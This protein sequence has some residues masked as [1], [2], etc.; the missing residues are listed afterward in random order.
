MVINFRFYGLLKDYKSGRRS[1]LSSRI[2]ERAPSE[3]IVEAKAWFQQ[4]VE[5]SGDRMPDKDLIYLTTCL[6]KK[7]LF[8][9]YVMHMERY[10]KKTISY[11]TFIRVW[12][13]YFSKVTIPKVFT[14]LCN[15]LLFFLIFLHFIIRPAL[16]RSVPYVFC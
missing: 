9:D 4:M 6:K 14:S 1:A 2:G 15:R 16:S 13:T 3:H 10:E 5:I 12:K 7:D 8:N 11:H